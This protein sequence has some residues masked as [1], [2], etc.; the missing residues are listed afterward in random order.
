MVVTG[1][2]TGNI[3][4]SQISLAFESSVSL[5]EVSDVQQHDRLRCP[6]TQPSCNDSSPCHIPVLVSQSTEQSRN[7]KEIQHRSSFNSRLSF[8]ICFV[9]LGKKRERK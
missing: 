1:G 6:K 3:S 4:K 5:E 8:P 9:S 2:N 7:P